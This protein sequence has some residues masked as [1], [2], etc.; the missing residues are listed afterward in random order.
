MPAMMWH[1]FPIPIIEEMAH[2]LCY[3]DVCPI[4]VLPLV[5]L[6]YER[7]MFL[8]KIFFVKFSYEE[9]VPLI[10]YI[11]YHGKLFPVIGTF[12]SEEV[13][14]SFTDELMVYS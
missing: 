9:N 14:L 12:Y 4:Q 8:E 6:A 5:V 1:G 11:K 10:E 2:I 13:K 3:Y 7:V